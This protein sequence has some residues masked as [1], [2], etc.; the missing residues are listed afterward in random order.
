MMVEGNE[1]VTNCNQL[2]RRATDE[3]KFLHRCNIF[4]FQLHNDRECSIKT[5]YV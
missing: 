2:K 3:K 1:L 4:V 5:L